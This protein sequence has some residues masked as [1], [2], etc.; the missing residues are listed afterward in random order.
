MVIPGAEITRSMPPGHFNAIFIEDANALNRS[1]VMEVFREAKRQ[2][3]F[4]FWNHPHWTSQQPDG[5]ATLTEM[6]LKLLEEGLFSGIEVVNETTYSDEALEI[7]RQNHLTLMGNSDI[8]GL[9][10]QQYQSDQ[11]KHRP[12]TL[13]FAKE[14]T[15]ESLKQAL[16]GHRT[17]VWFDNTLVGDPAFLVPLVEQSLEVKRAPARRVERITLVNHADA[18]YILENVSGFR[19]HNHAAIVVVKAHTSTT[20]L[21]KT[22]E[23]RDTFDL[24]FNVLNAFTSPGTHPVITLQINDVNQPHPHPSTTPSFP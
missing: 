15:P 17:V 12:V 2:G 5:V 19:L 10:D 14:R 18:D 24:R 23:E 7:A 21:V 13:V 11:G 22:L 4:V 16:I 6:H 20:L 1:D 9:I 3:A 8:H